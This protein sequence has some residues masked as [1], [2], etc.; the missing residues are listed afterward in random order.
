MADDGRGTGLDRNLELALRYFVIPVTLWLPPDLGHTRSLNKT[1]PGSVLIPADG[2]F[3]ATIP[4]PRA[5]LH[6]NGYTNFLGLHRLPSSQSFQGPDAD[7][8]V[9]AF[10]SC[11]TVVSTAKTI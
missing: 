10:H 3:L 2:P 6:H 8:D 9:D 4:H 11:E 7:V 1:V 5:F